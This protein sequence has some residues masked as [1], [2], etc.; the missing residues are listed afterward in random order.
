MAMVVAM[1]VKGELCYLYGCI[2]CAR[3]RGFV[4]RIRC[5]RVRAARM[6]P[7]PPPYISSSSIIIIIII[8]YRGIVR[9]VETTARAHRY[10]VLAGGDRSDYGA[11]DGYWRAML[12]RSRLY[13]GRPATFVL[14]L[15]LLWRDGRLL[16]GPRG[17]CNRM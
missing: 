7:P 5:T 6:H 11:R 9:A 17:V 10:C 14:I 16:Y 1:V 13:R 15:C 3:A 12:P 8:M 2:L 4:S